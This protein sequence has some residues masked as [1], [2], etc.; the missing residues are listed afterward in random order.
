[1]SAKTKL[2]WFELII[3]IISLLFVWELLLLQIELN[4]K[5]I[6]WNINV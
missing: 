2:W 1:M 6:V 3:T 4:F 5:W